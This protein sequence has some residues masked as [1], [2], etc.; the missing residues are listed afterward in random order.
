M[1]TTGRT[2]RHD[3]AN[4]LFS[5]FCESAL[6]SRYCFGGLI[7]QYLLMLTAGVFS[8]FF[9]GIPLTTTHL[10]LT[11]LLQPEYSCG[12][13]FSC[14]SVFT[15]KL[16]LTPENNSTLLHDRQLTGVTIAGFLGM[17]FN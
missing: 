2:D 15:C 10:S 17:Q 4:S 5:Q 1:P 14:I 3:E 9:N 13:V 8:Y 7:L 12:E 11:I 16:V 6:K